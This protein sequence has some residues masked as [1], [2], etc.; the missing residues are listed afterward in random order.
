MRWRVVC[1]L[2]DVILTFWPTSAFISVDL[3]TFG[4]PTIATMPQRKPVGVGAF[5]FGL[6]QVQIDARGMA[7]RW[8]SM[9]RIGDAGLHRVGYAGFVFDRCRHARRG[10][11]CA[12]RGFTAAMFVGAADDGFWLG[13]GGLCFGGLCFSSLHVYG[14]RFY[15]FWVR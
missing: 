2:R 15:R 13:F 10:R 9:A 14:L 7:R 5:I 1:A 3:P 8:Q 6:R 11:G 12:G 4:R